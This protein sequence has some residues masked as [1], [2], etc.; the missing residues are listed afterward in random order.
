MEAGDY[1]SAH[2]AYDAA[3]YQRAHA[4]DEAIDAF[5]AK[6]S[7]VGVTLAANAE[8]TY[9]STRTVSLALSSGAAA[10]GLLIG[11]FL[12]GTIARAVSQVARAAKGLAAG[13][14]EQRIEVRPRDEIGDMAEAFSEMVAYQQGMARVADAMSR[15]DLSQD[16]VP[17]GSSDVLGTSFQRM[18][19]NLRALVS[20]LEDAVRIKSQFVSMVSHEIRTPM[21][22]V[23]GMTGLLLDTTLDAQ[24]RQ[25]AEAVRRSAE[26]L[27]G[28]I[29]DILDFSKMEADKLAVEVVELTVAT[30]VGDATELETEPAH[31]RGID[32]LAHV[33]PDMP[34]VL[35]GDPGRLR[36]VLVNLVGNAIKF[37]DRGGQVLIRARTQTRTAELCVV[38]FEL[39]DTGIGIAP[40]VQPHLFQPF[41]QADG[42]TSR[43]Y[44]GTG[45]GLS[46]SKNSW[47]SWEARKR[48][49][50]GQHLLVHC[51]VRAR[52]AR[53]GGRWR[54]RANTVRASVG[55]RTTQ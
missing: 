46:I 36:Q 52:A 20:E 12:S 42:S 4:L 10:F 49:R 3:G 50:L 48:S 54:V 40:E 35:V 22:G 6:K 11:L 19:A 28:I 55:A 44:G 18:I 21:N 17:K 43:C 2:R 5:L 15:G 47:S 34:Q 53:S 29:N 7:D 51:A 8:P 37:T 33:H 24:Q 39:Q 27:L 31:G 25:Y 16:V 9:L 30:V 26:A 38:R 32:L 14:L 13:D 1:E 23:L 45:L 41:S